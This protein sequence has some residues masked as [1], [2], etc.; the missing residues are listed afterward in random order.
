MKFD[1]PSCSEPMKCPDKVAG[2]KATCP[3]CRQKILIPDLPSQSESG[4]NKATLGTQ[5]KEESQFGSSDEQMASDD[6]WD[7]KIETKDDRPSRVGRK[8][9]CSECGETILAKAIICP[10]C[11]CEQM[12][13]A[14]PK[15]PPPFAKDHEQEEESRVLRCF[16]W[17]CK[18]AFMTFESDAGRAVECPRCGSETKAPGKSSQ[19]GF[20]CVNCGTRQTLVKTTKISTGGVIFM[21]AMLFICFPFALLGLLMTEKKLF[22]QRCGTEV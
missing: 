15:T 6:I 10:K 5:T 2:M 4:T 22:C 19:S 18:K 11:G 7:G 12:A 21:I 17:K 16:C 3:K 8:K 1:C 14:H 20:K 9:E 13:M